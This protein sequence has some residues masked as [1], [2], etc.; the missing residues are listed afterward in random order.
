MARVRYMKSRLKDQKFCFFLHIFYCTSCQSVSQNNGFLGRKKN[1]ISQ[2][3][4]T[5]IV[6]MFKAI[7][8]TRQHGLQIMIAVQFFLYASYTFT[9]GEMYM[10]YFYMLKTFEGFD[11]AGYSIFYTY[12]CSKS[13]LGFIK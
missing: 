8:K 13:F 12:T 9:W 2:S 10:R 5:P 7:F 3:L 1:F 6:D 4:I 11:A